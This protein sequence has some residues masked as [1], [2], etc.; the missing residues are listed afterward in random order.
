MSY[1][2]YKFQLPAYNSCGKCAHL[3]VHREHLES[4]GGIGELDLARSSGQVLSRS[5]V[6]DLVSGTIGVVNNV[7]FS[8]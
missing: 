3:V 4:G 5:G 7:P 8:R 1:N 6:G 2:K